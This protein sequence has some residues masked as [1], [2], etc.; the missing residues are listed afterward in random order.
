MDSE[1]T[2][3]LLSK[4]TKLAVDAQKPLIIVENPNKT[5]NNAY[6]YTLGI[7]DVYVGFD[8][9]WPDDLIELYANLK[10]K[11]ELESAKDPQ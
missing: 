1:I 6:N 11:L 10:S 8:G 3:V 7:G 2:V 4:I 5:V 9:Y